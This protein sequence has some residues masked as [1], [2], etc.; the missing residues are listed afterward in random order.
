MRFE[1]LAVYD[2]GNARQWYTAAMNCA[3]CSVLRLGKLSIVPPYSSAGNNLHI[4]RRRKD[5]GSNLTS[6]VSFIEVL[7]RASLNTFI[8][9]VPQILKRSG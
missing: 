6:N 8:S 3:A 9:L 1:L 4:W 7:T 5:T 2:A